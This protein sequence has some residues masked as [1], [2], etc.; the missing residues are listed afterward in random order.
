[1]GFFLFFVVVVVVLLCLD[2]EAVEQVA[3]RGCIVSILG[4]FQDQLD[5]TLRNVF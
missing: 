4:G 1:M 5:K 2:S 3:Q